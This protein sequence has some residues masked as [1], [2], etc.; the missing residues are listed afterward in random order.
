MPGATEQV[1]PPS[2]AMNFTPAVVTQPPCP[3]QTPLPVQT[4]PVVN[5]YPPPPPPHTQRS[6]GQVQYRPH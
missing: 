3:L 1:L 6:W 4:P 2:A 5:V